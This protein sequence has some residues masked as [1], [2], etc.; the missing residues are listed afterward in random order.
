MG[1]LQLTIF[2]VGYIKHNAS[3]I[4]EHFFGLSLSADFIPLS[5]IQFHR[6]FFLQFTD[7]VFLEF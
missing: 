6:V 7:P 3:Q 1:L 4:V 2:N 5:L